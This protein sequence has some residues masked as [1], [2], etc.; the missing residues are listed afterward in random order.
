M[1]IFKMPGSDLNKEQLL[2]ISI[3][4]AN[5]K[6]Q[7]MKDY[8]AAQKIINNKI[9]VFNQQEIKDAHSKP[10]TQGIGK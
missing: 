4:N 3:A 5:K 10:D 1:S 8:E 9:A 7:V 6:D 2:D